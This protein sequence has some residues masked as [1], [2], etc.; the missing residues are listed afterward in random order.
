MSGESPLSPVRQRPKSLGQKKPIGSMCNQS[1]DSSPVFRRRPKNSGGAAAVGADSADVS[2]QPGDHSGD[3]GGAAAVVAE[4]AESA[5]VS[6]QPKPPKRSKR[7]RHLKNKFVAWQAKEDKGGISMSGSENSS[8]DDDKSDLS[9]VSQTGDHSNADRHVYLAS[10]SSQGGFPT[11]MHK[12]RQKDS[13]MI[14]VA[15]MNFFISK[16]DAIKMI[17]TN[18]NIFV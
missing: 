6:S 3:S 1:S 8:D 15:G 17:F 9:C 2:S 7:Y 10:L 16:Y 11:P 14:P 18:F 12:R 5:D 13:G 4:S